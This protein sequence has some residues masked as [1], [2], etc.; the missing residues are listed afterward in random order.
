MENFFTRFR[1][2]T[3]VAGILLAQIILLA[4]QVQVSD[5]AVADPNQKIT[6][7][8]SWGEAVVAPFQRASIHTGQGLRSLWNDYLDLRH[9]REENEKLTAEVNRLRLD[10]AHIQQDA[11]QGHRLQSL[12]DFKEQFIAHTL[13][14][15]V[16]GTSGTDL[17]RVLYVDRGT[18][19]GVLNGMAVVTPDGIAGK[20]L[21]ADS[22]RS[23]VLLINDATSGAGVML[24]R[25]RIKGVLKGSNS[26]RPEIINVM[27]DEKIEPGD[28][29]ITTGGDGVYPKGL[30]VGT[31]ESVSPDKERD[32]F[33][34]IRVKPAVNLSQLEEVLIITEMAVR[35]PQ[36]LETGSGSGTTRAADL[37]SLRLPSAK[38]KTD[39]TVDANSVPVSTKD[40]AKPADSKPAI[41]KPNLIM[42]NKN[43]AVATDKK[44]PAEPAAVPKKQTPDGRDSGH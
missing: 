43:N 12:L 18:H 41:V 28:K 26:G 6:L 8:R 42:D 39:D 14:A 33:L 4:M 21:H 27:A 40:L 34:L 29:V 19:D 36:Q 10:Q 30:Q 15:Q 16:I 24:E 25:Q 20:I 1:T 7:I 3:I 17:S 44:K 23:Q 31:V 5:S 32:P 37:L 35:A 11:A 38:K 9:V 2:E 13:A 22:N